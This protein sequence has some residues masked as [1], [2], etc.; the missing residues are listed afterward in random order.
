VASGESPRNAGLRLRLQVR[1]NTVASASVLSTDLFRYYRYSVVE[2]RMLAWG[3][4]Q[5][6]PRIQ[7]RAPFG[8]SGA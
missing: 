5:D 1:N 6:V 3:S 7:R 8:S 4:V 2:E